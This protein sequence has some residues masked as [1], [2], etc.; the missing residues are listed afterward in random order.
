MGRRENIFFKN[1]NK[2]YLT[3]SKQNHVMNQFV[4]ITYT[5]YIHL[6]K[7]DQGGH[8][9]IVVQL[10]NNHSKD[11]LKKLGLIKGQVVEQDC[12]RA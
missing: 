7:C 4:I 1:K 5:T 12:W 10:R 2:Y 6:Q 8:A 11:K 3:V 9:Q